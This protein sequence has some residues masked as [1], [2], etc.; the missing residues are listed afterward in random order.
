MSRRGGRS[1][2]RPKKTTDPMIGRTVDLTIDDIGSG[3]DGIG[4]FDGHAIYVPLALPGDALTVRLSARRG[5]GYAAE[6]V[7]TR[8][9]MPRQSPACRHFGACGGCRLQ[10]LAPVD[11]RSWKR[12]RVVS[13]L[14]NR[15]MTDVEIRPLIDTNP[16]TRRRLRLAFHPMNQSVGLGFRRRLG[17]EIVDVKECAIA[18][19]II[20]DLLTPLRT[21]LAS[22]ELAAKPGEVSITSADNGLD[23]LLQA[24]IEPNLGDREALAAFAESEDLA[25]LA[26]RSETAAPAEPVAARRQPMVD[27]GGIPIDLPIGA[28]LQATDDAERAI[29]DAVAKAIDGS[30]TIAD[31]FAGCGA[32]SLPFAGE[33][34]RILAIERDPAMIHA[35]NA[36]TRTS[37]LASKVDA[38][39]RDLDREPLSGDELERFDAVILDP[40]RAGARAQVEAIAASEGPQRIAM[41][42]CNPAT[43]ARDART[44]IDAG[45]C[46][47]WVQPIDAFLY[48]ADIELVG[49]FEHTKAS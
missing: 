13:A 30:E 35:L 48:A 18:L 8:A 4:R 2:R 45:Y 28:F 34:R 36:A 23:L 40:P 16:A 32:L 24:P 6:R 27:V 3:G 7:E 39:S 29:R 33:S 20:V 41:V 1:A 15:G 12:Q 43:F 25:R 9:L 17:K 49:A 46:L 5:T 42:S 14:A 21:C 11:Y 38:V 10:H 26:W 22:L 47:L 37:G 31:L 44:L 19:P